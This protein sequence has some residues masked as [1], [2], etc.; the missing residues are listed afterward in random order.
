MD[1]GEALANIGFDW[2]MAI[3]NLVNFLVVFWLLARFVFKPMKATLKERRDK[4]TQG[5]ENA[6]KAE[7]E[8]MQAQVKYDEKVSQGKQDANEIVANSR[9]RATAL[10]DE[11]QAEATVQAEKILEE[12]RAKAD[13]ERADMQHSVAE[14]AATLVTES[15]EKI[16]RSKIDTKES[17][18]IIKESLVART[19]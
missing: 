16:L 10:A 15:V 6:Q 5:V 9:V 1:I 14:Y 8:L 11:L 13:R 7:T 19:Q 4:I 3:A 18:R 2:R 12:A 17:E